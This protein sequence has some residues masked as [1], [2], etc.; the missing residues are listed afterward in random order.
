M[1]FVSD[2]INTFIG[3]VFVALMTFSYIVS[4]LLKSIKGLF[5]FIKP[6]ITEI[7]ADISLLLLLS[8]Q[9]LLSIFSSISLRMSKFLFCI[10]KV[11]HKK[12]EEIINRLWIN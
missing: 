3:F 5:G 2:F 10:S 7:L 9:M 8:Y 4:E 6:L 11:S 1:K 12:S